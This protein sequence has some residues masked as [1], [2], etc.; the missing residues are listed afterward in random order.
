MNQ[1]VETMRTLSDLSGPKGL[2]LL[3]NLLQLN[4]KQ[5]IVSSSGGG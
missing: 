3:G 4:F 2:P 5:S 1:A